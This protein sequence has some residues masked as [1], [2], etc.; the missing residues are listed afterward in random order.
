MTARAFVLVCTIP[1]AFACDEGRFRGEAGESCLARDDC[2]AGLRCIA[3][4]CTG[5]GGGA[6]DAGA[7]MRDNGAAVVP[8]PSSVVGGGARGRRGE[9]CQATNDC[10]DGLGCVTQ[11][12]RDVTVPLGHTPKSCHR[13]ECATDDECCDDF[14]PHTNCATYEANCAMDPVFCNTYRSLCQCSRR[15]EADL[16]VEAPPGCGADAECTSA[17]T[18]YCVEGA[19]AQCAKDAQCPGVGAKCRDGV[20]AAPCVQDEECA[21]LEACRDG[22]CVDVGCQSDRECAFLMQ[23]ALARCSDGACRIPCASDAECAEMAFQ[24]CAEG[25]CLFVGCETDVECRAY[26]GLQRTTERARAVCK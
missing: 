13:V 11:V 22:D 16:C 10:V 26:L 23:H 15:C 12:C 8:A 25:Q 14:V 19:C 4:V 5:S 7:I 1:F 18:P 2:A 17:Q 20:C 9:S 3:Q 6:S 21:L 24:V